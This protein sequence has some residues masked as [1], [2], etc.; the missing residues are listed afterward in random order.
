MPFGQKF[1]GAR[2]ADIPA[3]Y[4]DRIYNFIVDKNINSLA[5]RAVKIYIDENRDIIDKQLKEEK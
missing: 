2:M 4:L 3:W 1:R 5:A